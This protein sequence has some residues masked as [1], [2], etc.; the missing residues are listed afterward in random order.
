MDNSINTRFVGVPHRGISKEQVTKAKQSVKENST[1][2]VV[3]GTLG[4]GTFQALRNSSKIGNSA[5]KLIQESKLIQASNKAKIL[6][7]F[8]KGKFLKHPVVKKIAGPLAAFAALSTV[9]GSAAKIADTCQ[10][11]EGQRPI[12]NA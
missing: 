7:I 9:V 3:G 2:M 5:M 6:K 12:A 8:E 10:Y 4:A 1:E 11:I